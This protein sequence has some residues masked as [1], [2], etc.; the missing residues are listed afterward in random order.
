MCMPRLFVV[1]LGQCQE[2]NEQ[3]YAKCE[4]DSRTG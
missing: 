4:A 3:K 1:F 2:A